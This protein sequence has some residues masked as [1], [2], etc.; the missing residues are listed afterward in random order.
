MT[1]DRITVG[2]LLF[3]EMTQLD[4]TGP[5]EVFASMPRTTVE[6]VGKTLPPVTT[7][8]ALRMLPPEAIAPCRWLSRDELALLGAAPVAVRIVKDRMGIPGG[9]APWGIDFA[10]FVAAQL[11]GEAVAREIHPRTGYAPAPPLNGGS[12]RTADPALV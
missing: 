3:P 8:R 12:P 4:M 11:C 2:L 9:G 10:L 6:A 1:D 7:R 5:Y